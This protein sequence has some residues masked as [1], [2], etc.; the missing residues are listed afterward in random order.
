MD[1]RF[2]MEIPSAFIFD[3]EGATKQVTLIIYYF[4]TDNNLLLKFATQKLTSY[5]IF[6]ISK[7]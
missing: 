1:P 4:Y 3:P 2:F 7:G 5:H 6:S